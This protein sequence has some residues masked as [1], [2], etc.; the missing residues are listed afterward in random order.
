MKSSQNRK[1]VVFSQARFDQQLN[2]ARKLVQLARKEDCSR[3]GGASE[4]R[5]HRAPHARTDP[6]RPP[7][8]PTALTL[9]LTMTYSGITNP[10]STGS[11]IGSMKIGFSSMS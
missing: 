5:M 2:A 10:T 11:G 1:R 4:R 8:A 6:R 7:T 9:R 3:F